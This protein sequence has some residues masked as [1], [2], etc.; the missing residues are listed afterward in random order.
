[1]QW[2]R[3]KNLCEG[4]L[5]I[6]IN[7]N[8]IYKKFKISNRKVIPPPP[9]VDQPPL[10][11]LYPLLSKRNF[12]TPPQEWQLQKRLT[13]PFN[14]GVVP[15]MIL[16]AINETDSVPYVTVLE[17]LLYKS[18]SSLRQ[19]GVGD[20]TWKSSFISD[21]FRGFLGILLPKQGILERL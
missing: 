1:M 3:Q 11:S 8:T 16:G 6:S 10:F 5:L 20:L 9:T 21:I 12:L 7:I 17:F 4:I 18:F 19:Y 14:K 15:N 13:P 2:Q